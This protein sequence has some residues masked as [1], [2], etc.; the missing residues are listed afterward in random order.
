[1]TGEWIAVTV[2]ARGQAARRLGR[3]GVRALARS[4]SLAAAIAGLDRT[5]Y[6]RDV[7]PGMD[8]AAAERAVW[9]TLLW[10]L[11]VLAGW[12][13][14]RGMDRVRLLAA[15]FE[16][17]NVLN[18]LAAIGGRSAAAPYEIG[19]L[20]TAWTTVA[21]AGTADDVRR[22]LAASAWGDP[23]GS[24]IAVVALGLQTAWARRVA[25]G[26]PEAAGWATAFA[27]LMLARMRAAGTSPVPGSLT[28]RNV[29]LVR[30][31]A[32]PALAS[33][34]VP[35]DLWQAE[36]RIWGL[37][38][39]QALRMHA[40]WRPGP[41]AIVAVAGLLAADA[42][43]TRAALEVAARGGAAAEVLDVVA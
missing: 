41:A 10:H 42:W 32:A 17:A 31:R 4:G 26:V 13:P 37:I 7:R 15:G 27:E 3:D 16:I 35:S 28:E 18:H 5:P 23:G 38:E 22:A 11:R 25:F 40:G 2:R 29:R 6:D 36:A 14:S 19:R 1:V 12:A 30:G 33:G 20:T 43:R 34:G 9:S 21:R 24:D 39:A 8:L